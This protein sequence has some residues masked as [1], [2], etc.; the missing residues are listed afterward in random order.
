MS[1]AIGSPPPRGGPVGLGI[2][3]GGTQTRWALADS[4]GEIVA[5][6]AVRGMSAM[7]IGQGTYI[8]DGVAEIAAA[9]APHGTPARIQAGL[10]GYVG[11]NTEALQAAIA[12]PFRLEAGG[13]AVATDMEMAFRDLFAP[14]AGYMVY[15]GTG[16]VAAFVD[17][18]GQLHRAGGR[19]VIVDDGGSGFWIARQAMRHV[20]RREDEAPGSWRD[21]P[22]A[23]ALF[24]AVGGSDWASSREFIYGGDRGAVGRLALVVAK[25][26]GED[27]A[28]REILASAGKELARLGNAMVRRY[29]QRPIAVAGRAVRIHPVIF[30]SLRATVPPGIA[31]EMREARGHHAAAR[32]ALSKD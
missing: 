32:L 11:V 2:D 23:V 29:G 18:R 19:G 8:S 3:A 21:S 9:V 1:D 22:L 31:V 12:A 15:A 13:V 20:W 14:G 26:A 6:G 25:V 7:Q 28:A 16:S 4:R 30:E 5:E 27:A 17:E 10:T 24:E